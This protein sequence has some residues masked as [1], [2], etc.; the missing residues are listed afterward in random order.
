MEKESFFPKLIRAGLDNDQRTIRSLSMKLI[1]RFKQT[2]PAVAEEI[3][4]ALSYNGV[5]IEA[6]R[7][8][9]IESS[10]LDSDS[11]LNLITVEEPYNT[12]RPILSEKLN[13]AI[14]DF[15][16]ERQQLSKL[17]SAGLNPSSSIIVYGPP[18]VGKT[19]LARYLSGVFNL[20]FA[21]LNL[22]T[23][24]SSYLGKTGQN[25]KS[26]L[27][28][29]RKEPTLLLL[30]E[31]DAIAKKRDDASD[32][33]ELKRIVNVLLKELEDWPHFSIIIAATN[34]PD[35]LDKAIWR[36]FDINLEITLPAKEQRYQILKRQFES[37][38]INIKDSV[39]NVIAEMIENLSAADICK[40]AERSKRK[41]LINNQ[42][43]VKVLIIELLGL[44]ESDNVGFNKKFC[45]LV[46][47]EAKVPI[48]TLASWL[49]KSHSTIQYY[50]KESESEENG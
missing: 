17:I 42:D 8:I 16:N 23:S 41:A 46:R 13:I 2:N 49:D 48:R 24:I 29:A 15:I 5:G 35:L 20:K 26:V 40:L 38:E 39:L 18:G 44:Y 6:K 45:K 43:L 7:S 34:H 47:Q 28:Y 12:K 19:Y 37:E 30:D 22:A 9:G 25:L 21:T 33:G 11:R 3:A 14:D 32:L 27:D 36:R 4:N 1:R 50:L 31:F 10:P